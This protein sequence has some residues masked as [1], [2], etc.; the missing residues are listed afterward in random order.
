MRETIAYICDVCG[1]FDENK[2]NL[3]KHEFYCLKEKEREIKYRKD[4]EST[5]QLT[6]GQIIK[7]CESLPNLPIIIFCNQKDNLYGYLGSVPCDTDS[8]RGY[9]DELAIEVKVGA[10]YLNEF[11]KM[12]KDSL[13]RVY[14]GYKCGEYSMY[15]DTFVWV[16]PNGVS[17][18]LA[19]VDVRLAE[20]EKTIQLVIKTV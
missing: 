2:D 5:G 3:I 15:E 11:K 17:T 7:K 18:D 8:Y 6:I 13:N 20:D 12:M 16:A 1:T 10:V 4:R 14:F 19:V 9:Y